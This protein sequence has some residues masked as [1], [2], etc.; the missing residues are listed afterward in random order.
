MLGIVT[1][2]LTAFYAF[3]L[4]FVAFYGKSRLD[5]KLER[6]VHESPTVMVVPMVILAV[7]AVFGGYIGLPGFLGLGNAI[8][9]FLHPVF[10]GA[11]PH[12]AEANVTTEV[13]LMGVSIVAAAIGFFL[14]YWIYIRKWG[15]AAR[16]TKSLQWLYDIVY[17]KYYVDEAYM[18]VVVQPL[19]SLAG[20]L[21]DIVEERTIDAAV[22]GL[23]Q[24]VG[25]AGEGVRRLQT[26]L[27]RNYA[28][29]M[30]LG[31]VAI[32]VYFVVRGI[33]GY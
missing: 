33:L 15:L 1:A 27:V 2:G 13:S 32:I 14:A 18:E 10:A 22:N 20:F 6:Q 19:R 29:A 3:R 5:K 11:M 25:L 8:D 7:L 21:T 16:V 17:N 4:L 26:G 12:A 31:V 28:L 23:A 30:F 9:E 24:V